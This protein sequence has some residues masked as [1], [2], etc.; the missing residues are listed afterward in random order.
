M[1]CVRRSACTDLGVR[2]TI[3]V[4]LKRIHSEAGRFSL[5]HQLR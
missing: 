5:M 1:P 2:R 4:E 3:A